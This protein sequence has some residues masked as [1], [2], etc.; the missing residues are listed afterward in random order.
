MLP[1]KI[2]VVPR[3]IQSAACALAC[4]LATA[5]LFNA[6][7]GGADQQATL[8]KVGIFHAVDVEFNTDPDYLNSINA[9]KFYSDEVLN[10]LSPY[11]CSQI[12][13]FGIA[14]TAQPALT[15]SVCSEDRME[16]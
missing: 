16:W 6:A 8:K 15:L 13:G 7:T 11:I 1:P 12:R 4:N 5:D 3:A 9:R 2:A 10:Y 14:P